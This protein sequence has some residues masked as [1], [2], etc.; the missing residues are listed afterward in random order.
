MVRRWT[1]FAAMGRG[2]VRAVGKEEKAEDAA[3]ERAVNER[4]QDMTGGEQDKMRL[5]R[6]LRVACPAFGP[7]RIE[8]D[9][10]EAI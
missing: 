9:L 6:V 3:K 1:S 10:P 4:M 8:V 5:P 2:K 7:G